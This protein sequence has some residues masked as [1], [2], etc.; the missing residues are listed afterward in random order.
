MTAAESPGPALAERAE[1]RQLTIMFCDV[2]DSVGLSTRLDPEDLRDV[3]TA[4]HQVCARSIGLY[5]GYVARYLGD[6]VLVY[7]GYPE[8]HEDDA[9]RGVRAALNLV[10]AVAERKHELGPFPMS[11]CGCASASPPG[12]LS[13][14]TSNQVPSRRWARLQEKL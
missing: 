4:Y 2:V 5:N 14:A 11:I 8:A 13:S 9:E 7:F 10:Q 3:I 12:S 1:R 6:G